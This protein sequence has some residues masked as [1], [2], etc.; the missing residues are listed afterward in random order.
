MGIMP[1][2]K[3]EVVKRETSHNDS[4]DSDSDGIGLRR[5]GQTGKSETDSTDSDNRR[6]SRTPPLPSTVDG[7]S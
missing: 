7:G 3:V 1:W 4:A 6:D 2:E 5:K